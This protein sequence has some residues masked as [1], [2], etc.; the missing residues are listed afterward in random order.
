MTIGK[1]TATSQQ[2]EDKLSAEAYRIK[3]YEQWDRNFDLN[4]EEALSTLAYEIDCY[5][6]DRTICLNILAI[7]ED[8]PHLPDITKEALAERK[9]RLIAGLDAVRTRLAI[10]GL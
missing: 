1:G 10:G 3:A 8:A 6:A 4:F 2:V 5:L 9:S 7:P